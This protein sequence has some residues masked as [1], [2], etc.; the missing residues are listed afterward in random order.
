MNLIAATDV[1]SEQAIHASANNDMKDT[2]RA[3]C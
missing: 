1:D 3:N 2:F